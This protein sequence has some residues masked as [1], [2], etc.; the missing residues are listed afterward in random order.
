M[1]YTH[2]AYASSKCENNIGCAYN[3][4]MKLLPSDDDW[5]VL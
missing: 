5:T 2:I 3:Q 1:I 4:F